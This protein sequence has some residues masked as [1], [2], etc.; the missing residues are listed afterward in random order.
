MSGSRL[1]APLAVLSLVVFGWQSALMRWCGL[2]AYTAHMRSQLLCNSVVAW[3]WLAAMVCASRMQL[4][5]ELVLAAAAYVVWDVVKSAV[6]AYQQWHSDD[7]PQRRRDVQQLG[8][9]VATANGMAAAGG[10]VASLAGAM[11]GR[12]E[13]TQARAATALSAIERRPV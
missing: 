8:N 12:L 10:S 2:P 5:S 9:S 13:G 3:L 11:A 1:R 7:L 6:A 4:P